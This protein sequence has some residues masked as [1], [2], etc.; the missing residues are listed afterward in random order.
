VIV[1]RRPAALLSA[2][3]LVL[4]ARHDARAEQGVAYPLSVRIEGFVGAKPQD[5]KPL[6]SWQVGRGRTVYQLHVT[7]LRVLSGQAAYFNIISRLEPYRP[8]FWLAGDRKALAA[9]ASTP[10]GQ[11]I[12]I[13]GYLRLD[14]T[15]RVLMLSTVEPLPAPSPPPG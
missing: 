7:V 2:A 1:G 12:A 4:A 15:T 8:A 11:P 9:F 3:L 5:L 14:R 13:M 10:A 6:V